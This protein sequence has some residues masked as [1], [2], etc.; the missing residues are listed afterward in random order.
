M[1]D[2]FKYIDL[3]AV[4]VFYV[5]LVEF[6]RGTLFNIFEEKAKRGTNNYYLLPACPKSFKLGQ[7]S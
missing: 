2:C 1:L 4:T 7:P 3:D 5:Q 6:R